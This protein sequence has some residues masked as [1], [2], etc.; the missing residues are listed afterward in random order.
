MNPTERPALILTPPVPIDNFELFLAPIHQW[1]LY[2]FYCRAF[3]YTDHGA[4]G[5]TLEL[6][7]FLHGDCVHARSEVKPATEVEIGFRF[8]GVDVI[9]IANV[10]PRNMVIIDYEFRVQETVSERGP[11][12]YVQLA[13]IG[14]QFQFLCR[15]V[16]V[17][18]AREHFIR[19]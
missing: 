4:T 3:R 13:F 2:D 18:H 1:N 10:A 11:T 14:G 7:L 16:A 5:A 6:D 15:S 17:V 12:I 9:E 8:D 19:T